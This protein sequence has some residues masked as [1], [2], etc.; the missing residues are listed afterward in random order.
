MCIRACACVYKIEY[1]M[2]AQQYHCEKTACVDE[3]EAVAIYIGHSVLSLPTL[4]PHTYIHAYSLYIT[5]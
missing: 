1:V 3:N 5:K 4:T 2:L